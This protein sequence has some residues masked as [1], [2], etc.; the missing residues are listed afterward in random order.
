[1]SL[2]TD[3][4]FGQD[5]M[6][7]NDL[8]VKVAANGELVLTDNVET[9]IQDIKLVIYTYIGTLFYDASFGSLVLDWVKEE[10]TALARMGFEAEVRKRIDRQARV[11]LNSAACRIIKWDE[12][13][14]LADVS[15]QFIDDDNIYN[16]V[17]E[18]GQSMEMVIKNVEPAYI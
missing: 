15:W 9:G 13:G 6:L 5:I 11:K 4:L 17:I 14:I 18:T 12:K 16:L 2:Q 8:Q 3:D 1:M 10:N 7:D